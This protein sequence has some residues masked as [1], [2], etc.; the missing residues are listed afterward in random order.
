MHHAEMI[1]L[2]DLMQSVKRMM[3]LIE[4]IGFLDLTEL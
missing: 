2:L 1:E 3:H 4:M